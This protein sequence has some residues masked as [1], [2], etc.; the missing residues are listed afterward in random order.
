MDPGDSDAII[1]D[2]PVHAAAP[3]EALAAA[4]Q[5]QPA[6][7]ALP[8]AAR[9]TA[10]RKLRAEI[11]NRSDD[12]VA[13]LCA[14]TGRPLWE[15]REEVQTMHVD[16]DAYIEHSLAELALCNPPPAKSQVQFRPAGVVAVI[17]PY[18]Q[19]A[20]LLHQDAVA[21]MLAGCSVVCKPSEHTPATAQ[22]YAE[23]VHEADLPRGVFNLIQGDASVGD[24]LASDLA[25]DGV[26]FSGSLA[27][28]QRLQ[29]AL[30]GSRKLLRTQLW[31]NAAALVLDDADLEEAAYQIV[32]GACI[33]SGQRCSSTHRVVV[34]QR[35]AERLL[36]RVVEVMQ[37]LKVGYATDPGTFMGPLISA[38]AVDRYLEQLKQ[39][40]ALGGKELVHGAPLS[41]RR[42][43]FY[44]TPSLHQ[45]PP[46]ALGPAG[47]QELAGPLLVLTV[48]DDVEQGVVQA[49]GG[50][51]SCL[52]LSVFTR[53]PR[54][55]AQVAQLHRAALCLQNLPTTHIPTHLPLQ[56]PTNNGP[57]AGVLSARACTRLSVLVQREAALDVTMLPPG[58]PRT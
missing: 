41:S 29:Q 33:S 50:H 35:V 31:G 54:A 53:S 4:H 55:V 13:V 1:G 23:I 11:R 48:V 40:G 24:A 34:Q 58:L 36:Q 16:L 25:T 5:A 46:E 9:A 51:C 8:A 47:Q 26:L 10:L 52:V 42:R 21:A 56:Q 43:G 19:P 37:Q 6:W 44:V 18:P 32:I 12:L 22:V 45:V 57:M 15:T 3:A 17:T 20:L 30:C 38:R 39:L 7:D 49:A 28:G 14:E 27:A 2:F